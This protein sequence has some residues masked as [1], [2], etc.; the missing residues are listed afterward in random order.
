MQGQLLNSTSNFIR[1]YLIKKER[2][3]MRRT[4]VT[5]KE[6]DCLITVRENGSE[7]FPIRLCEI[8]KLMGI[9]PP[10][11]LE[12]VER[13]EGKGLLKSRSGMIR[14]TPQGLRE[15]ERIILNHRVFESLFVQSGISADEA[16]KETESFDYFLDSRTAEAVHR[17]I[18]SPSFCPHGKPIKAKA[19]GA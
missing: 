2:Y 1:Y 14:L 18:G 12:L 6:R 16:C 13:L 7:P 3:V 10:S 19:G 8:A 9:R 17:K 4:G 5:K 11:A 15:Y